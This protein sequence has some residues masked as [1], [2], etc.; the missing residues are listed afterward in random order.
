MLFKLRL[1]KGLALFICCT[2]VLAQRATSERLSSVYFSVP[3]YDLNTNPSSLKYLFA[4]G[5]TR[6]KSPKTFEAQEICVATG[7]KN[8]LKDAKKVTVYRYK[9][10]AE[11]SDSYL[12]I[13]DANGDIV[14]AKEFNNWDR[15]GSIVNETMDLFYG[16]DTCYWHPKLLEEAWDKDKAEW[17]QVQHESIKAQFYEDAKHKAEAA[18]MAGYTNYSISVYSGKGGKHDY[19]DLD[20]AQSQAIAAYTKMHKAGKVTSAFL[21]ELMVPVNTWLSLVDNADMG[22]KKAKLNLKVTQ[23]LY[24]N[25]AT[26]YFQ[27]RDF[28]KALQYLELHEDTHTNALM[29]GSS[30]YVT[31]LSK[32]IVDQQKGMAVN[33]NLTNNYADLNSKTMTSDLSIT[34]EDVGAGMVNELSGRFHFYNKDQKKEASVA[35]SGSVYKNNI[36][37]G[38]YG[39]TLV[40]MTVFDG[41]LEEFPVE[42]TQLN[43]KGLVFTG[44][45]SFDSLPP[46]IGNMTDLQQINLTD[47]NIASVPEEI[48]NL[49]NLKRLNLSKT[50]IT[51]LPES[52][53]NLKSLKMLNIKKTN[54][55]EA[56]VA[57]IQSWLPKGCKVK[58]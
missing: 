35:A 11:I 3:A 34:L 55:S 57:K 31:T 6:F 43:V 32:L 58:Y 54:I 9:V 21:E 16:E 1:L 23:G 14:Y 2:S 19:S 52:I 18:M 56:E 50:P 7:S 37:Q 29:R 44:G 53:K 36:N 48:G 39:P 40:M 12:I 41:D 47:S 42:V 25:L 46:E 4:I 30:Q 38:Q 22:N 5:D 45:Y 17:K 27:A 49:T 24:L 28:D 20:L 13:E 33:A 8:I 26:A 10:P 15:N 51:T